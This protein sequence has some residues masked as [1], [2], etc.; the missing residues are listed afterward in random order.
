MRQTEV[1]TK[2]CRSDLC[3]QGNFMSVA[4]KFKDRSQEE[5]EWQEQSARE[6]A[7]KLAKNGKISGA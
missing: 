1:E 3:A 4:P 6:V 2:I 5:T 7:W